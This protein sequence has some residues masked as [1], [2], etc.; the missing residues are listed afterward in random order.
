MN[1]IQDVSVNTLKLEGI[2]SS[3]TAGEYF[4]YQNLQQLSGV[5]MDNRGKQYIKSALRRLKLPYET[6]R[7]QGIRLLSKDNATK[8]VVRDVIRIDNSIKKAEKTTRQVKD[9]VYEQLTEGE[10]KNI[11]F[12]GALFGSI[13]SYSQSAK[14]IFKNDPLKIGEKVN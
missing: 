2:F 11:N 1:T 3:A 13:R 6:V 10:R 8:I 14:R 4:S 12:L 7:G 9:R 5:R